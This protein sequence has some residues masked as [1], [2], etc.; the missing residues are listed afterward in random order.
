MAEGER[1]RKRWGIAGPGG[2]SRGFGEGSQR[3]L[4]GFRQVSTI[5]S[6]KFLKVFSGWCKQQMWQQRSQQGGRRGGCW[7]LGP[8]YWQWDWTDVDHAGLIFGGG[9]DGNKG[10]QE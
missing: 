3:P 9:S 7:G 8:E 5:F 4:D 10:I 6:F 1:R 2:N